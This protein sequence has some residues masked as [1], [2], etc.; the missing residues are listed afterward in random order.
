MRFKPFVVTVEQR[1][2]Q[3][4]SDH[5]VLTEK[6]G[7]FAKGWLKVG[8]RLRIAKPTFIEPYVAQRAG[9]TLFSM[10]SFTYSR[11]CLPA[12][13]TVGRYSS[14]ASSVTVMG[15]G[16]PMDRLSTAPISY[17]NSNAIYH[18]AMEDRGDTFV[19]PRFRQVEPDVRIGNDVW[20]GGHAVLKRGV[21]IGHGAVVAA[22][23]VVTKDVPPYALVAGNP[24]RVRK[25]RFDDDMIA[26]LLELEWWNY[27]LA[28]LRRIGTTDPAAFAA[29][30]RKEKP[31]LQPWAPVPF[32]L[33][34]AF[35]G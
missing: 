26:E 23:T 10:G 4:L 20:I 13:S 30:L 34:E 2:L 7:N 33:H 32:S 19:E 9:P 27:H 15:V 21:T 24:G 5:R 35:A 1:H 31:S 11:S 16:H 6:T 14:I 17:D 29:A 8:Q 12:G 22:R 3:M 28:D 18:L 25:M